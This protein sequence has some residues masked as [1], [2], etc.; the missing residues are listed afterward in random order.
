MNWLDT[1][2]YV[3]AACGALVGLYLVVTG[4]DLPQ[5]LGTRLPTSGR[6]RRLLGAGARLPT[7]GRGRR[8]MGAGSLLFFLA[9]AILVWGLDKPQRGLSLLAVPI[10]LL[11]SLILSLRATAQ[12]NRPEV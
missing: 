7:S 8:V 2:I 11:P 9:I 6:G 3:I 1:G 5:W 4:R 10:L 12:P